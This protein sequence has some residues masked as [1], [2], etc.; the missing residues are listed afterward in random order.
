LGPNFIDFGE[1]TFIRGWDTN[2]S[3]SAIGQPAFRVVVRCKGEVADDSRVKVVRFPAIK[4]YPKQ[5]DALIM[6]SSRLFCY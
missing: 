3:A 5:L 4:S 6:G 2:T 1:P